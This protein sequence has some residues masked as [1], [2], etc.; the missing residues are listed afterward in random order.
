MVD[1]V[2]VG[3]PDASPPGSPPA[4]SAGVSFGLS[5]RPTWKIKKMS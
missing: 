4:L 1:A 3:E 5:H 2:D